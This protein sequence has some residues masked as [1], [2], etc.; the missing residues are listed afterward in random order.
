MG[1]PAYR[2]HPQGK[3]LCS[4]TSSPGHTKDLSCWGTRVAQSIKRPTLDF[5]S[6]HDLTVHGTGALPQVGLCT[7]SAETA[8]DFLSPSLSALPLLVLSLKI[9]KLKKKNLFSHAYF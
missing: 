2:Q 9:N 8:W 4:Q 6:G 7:D 1:E 3:D 5:G